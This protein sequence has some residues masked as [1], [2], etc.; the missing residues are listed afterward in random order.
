MFELNSFRF[1][2]KQKTRK[3]IS[4][5]N[6]FRW[7]YKFCVVVFAG[8]FSFPTRFV[9]IFGWVL[10]LP[11]IILSS[12]SLFSFS[13]PNPTVFDVLLDFMLETLRFWNAKSKNYLFFFHTFILGS[14]TRVLGIWSGQHG[15]PWWS[16]QPVR[17]TKK[18]NRS[19]RAEIP[20]PML[21]TIIHGQIDHLHKSPRHKHKKCF[22]IFVGLT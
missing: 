15:A 3:Q 13:L 8:L 6:M 10:L 7:G 4:V 9:V 21:S 17:I 18:K 5:K 2:Q 12:F 16:C 11:A 19:R 22:G 14:A 20:K 1:S